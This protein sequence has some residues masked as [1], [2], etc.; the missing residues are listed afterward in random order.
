MPH[1]LDG[2]HEKLERSHENIRNL[3]TEIDAFLQDAAYPVIPN[4][5]PA[6]VQ[7][8]AKLHTNRIIPRRFSI[9]SGEII[10]HLR[11]CLDHTA[12]QLS[13]PQKRLDDPSGIEFPIFSSKPPDKNTIRRYE[14]K[15]EGISDVGRE[16]IEA[17][18][19]YHR[20]PAFMLTGPLC[21]PLWIIHDMDRIDKHRELIM[22]LGAFDIAVPRMGMADI[23]LM[24]YRE[25]DFPEE[26]IVGLG[27]AFDPNSKI[28]TQVS[29]R[30][31]GGRKIQPVIPGLS[32]LARYV[33]DDVL[34]KFADD[35]LRPDN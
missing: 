12:W 20:D 8:A 29:F 26:D 3:K 7:E 11:S 24:L 34:L 25:S 10:H 35:Y 30:E 23:Y 33:H 21:D 16:I 4:D 2:V 17:L 31:F 28:A 5:D 15:V 27:R 14:R 32:K 18:Q 22:T 13:S 6:T 19:P 1:P 9:L